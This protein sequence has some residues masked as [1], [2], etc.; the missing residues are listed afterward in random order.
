MQ[1][2][3]E[4][5]KEKQ[6]VWLENILPQLK[7][8]LGNKEAFYEALEKALHNYLKATLQVE[9]SEISKRTYC[10]SFT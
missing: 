1:I 4:I 3:S 2:A 7:K 9:T 8:Q 5:E 10:S 6:I